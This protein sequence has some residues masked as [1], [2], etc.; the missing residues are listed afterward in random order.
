MI[1]TQTHK[2]YIHRNVMIKEGKL[3]DYEELYMHTERKHGTQAKVHT[4]Q[5]KS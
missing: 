4:L 3:F 5:N 1:N 2:F